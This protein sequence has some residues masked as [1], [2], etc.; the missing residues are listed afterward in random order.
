MRNRLPTVLL[1]GFLAVLGI[2]FVVGWP[3]AAPSEARGEP[4]TAKAPSAAELPPAEPA[5]RLAAAHFWQPLA[6]FGMKRA[7]IAAPDQHGDP[8]S[9]FPDLPGYQ[10]DILI[11]IVPDPVE[12]NS[13]YH[14]DDVVDAIQRAME[15]QGYVQDQVWFPW[16]TSAA[17]ARSRRSPIDVQV[18]TPAWAKLLSLSIQPE[19]D[20]G[21]WH[22]HEPGTLL[23]RRNL[24]HEGRDPQL[25]LVCLVGDTATRGMH[26]EAFTQ[27]LDLI[28]KS[29]AYRSSDQKEVRILGPAFSGSQTSLEMAVKAACQKEV[30]QFFSQFLALPAMAF[31]PAI[32][33]DAAL[34]TCPPLW[35]GPRFRVISG[36]ATAFEEGR[37]ST[38]C[39]PIPVSFQ[40]TV[41][42]ERLVVQELID[43]LHL[44]SRRVAILLEANTSLGRA[45][46]SDSPYTGSI[47]PA[48]PGV[49]IPYPLHIAE[50]RTAYEKVAQATPENVPRLPTFAGKLRVPAEEGPGANETEPSITPGMTAAYTERMLAQLLSTLARERIQYVMILGTDV[51][52]KIFLAGVLRQY[53]PDVQ[54]VLTE[55]DLLFSHPDHWAAFRGSV[56]GSTYPLY[57][58]N[59]G[60]SYGFGGGSKEEQRLFFPSQAEQGYY[61][62]TIAL[63]PQHDLKYLLEYGGPF[64]G[65]KTPWRKDKTEPA[66]LREESK[67]PGAKDETKRNYFRKENEPWQGGTATPRPPIW[68]SIV[69]QDGLHP[70]DFRRPVDPERN[71]AYSHYVFSEELDQPIPPPIPFYFS[72]FWVWV[73]AAV[74]LF[75]DA[76]FLMYLVV[77]GIRNGTAPGSGHWGEFTEWLC[78]L[79]AV[80]PFADAV[81]LM[82][83]VA[84]AIRRRA[85]FGNSRW[86][87]F[88]EWLRPRA[89]ASLRRMQAGY[90]LLCFLPLA[91]LCGFLLWLSWIPWTVVPSI[92]IFSWGPWVWS[93]ATF[94]LVTAALL[95]ATWYWLALLLDGSGLPA[96]PRAVPTRVPGAFGAAKRR[97]AALWARLR[98]FATR[99]FLLLGCTG[100]AVWYLTPLFT[101]ADFRPFPAPGPVHHEQA[102]IFYAERACDLAS[103]LSPLLPVLFLALAFF[104]WG[105]TQ[106]KRLE[107]LERPSGG[108]PFPDSACLRLGPLHN[109]YHQLRRIIRRPSV[110]GPLRPTWCLA[111]LVLV[112]A[113]CRLNSGF[114]PSVEGPVFDSLVWF[115][116]ALLCFLLVYGFAHTLG[117]WKQLKRLLQQTAQLRLNAAFGRIPRHLTALFGPYLSSP[118]PDRESHLAY[119]MEQLRS[120]ATHYGAARV[121]LRESVRISKERSE[122]DVAMC[123]GKEEEIAETVKRLAYYR[124]EAARHPAGQSLRFWVAGELEEGRERVFREEEEAC[125]KLA[126]GRIPGSPR[127]LG[128][129]VSRQIQLEFCSRA[130]QA[131]LTALA[132]CRATSPGRTPTERDA[133]PAPEAL[134]EG[135]GEEG[136]HKAAEEAAKD[137]P[138]A[139]AEEASEGRPLQNWLQQAEDLAAFEVAAFL[140]RF[141]VQLRNLV[142]FLIGGSILLLLAMT[143]YP[144]QP[145]GL[146]F[147]VIAALIVVFIAGLLKILIQME[148]DEV[149]SLILKTTP[150]RLN[151]GWSFV[152]HFALYVLPLLG[153]LAAASGGFSDLLH[154]WLDPVFQV[155]K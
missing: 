102:D 73:F 57:S 78:V 107:Q 118:R 152:S 133:A 46:F 132:R 119:R 48:A 115:G 125:L 69:G 11:A 14:F 58:R 90:T 13:G 60:R 8:W 32:G 137:S 22:E 34:L 95:Y 98:S 41:N 18:K 38:R 109:C 2:R 88:T 116:F 37:F 63:L 10:L 82:Y 70:L 77:G 51:R 94:V 28:K 74:M 25:V 151:L 144:F 155:L 150:Y 89:S 79:A 20:D 43:Y 56:V 72:R 53:Y 29:R 83:L 15:T 26:K 139:G 148:R 97:P 110:F 67:P 19:K 103:G 54:L 121:R 117:L 64:E 47:R 127:A 154:A 23:F 100:L 104:W 81:F 146:L 45:I 145:Q 126:Q 112:F 111:W 42:D 3:A 123:F 128:G 131:C 134:G 5:S 124:S 33:I 4:T 122:L 39:Y 36:S 61:N 55:S 71:L 44:N 66:P 27:S 120:L 143:S 99:R 91:V 65:P 6:D 62:A 141:F 76:I 49:Q 75:A 135:G 108:V 101:D 93:L 106:L 59:Q 21:P 153:A 96:R 35:S 52:D 17:P 68:I 142:F 12:S 114:V 136:G 129:P 113:L 147:L 24:V 85:S 105:Y 1:T 7:L 40:A 86:G 138:G 9:G 80:M 130:A 92:R 30:A 140:S 84:G 31:S 149:V 87:E 50:V 16:P